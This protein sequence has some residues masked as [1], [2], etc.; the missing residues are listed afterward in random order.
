MACNKALSTVACSFQFTNIADED[1]YL[2]KCNTPLEGLDSKF[3]TVS[4]EGCPVPYEGPIFYCMPPTKD[5]FVPL[6]AGEKISASVQITD[7]FSIDTDGLYIVQYCNP[8]QYLSENEISVMSNGKVRKLSVQESIYIYLENTRHLLKP[9][10]AEKPKIDYTVHLQACDSASFSNVTKKNKETL[11]AHKKL[12]SGIDTIKGKVANNAMY[13][14]WFGAHTSS[15]ESAVKTVFTNMKNGLSGS[16][17]TYYNNGPKCKS[18]T[19][20]YTYGSFNGSTIYLCNEYYDD[21][22]Y[23]ESTGYDKE[24]TL[25]HEWTHAHSNIDDYNDTYG[26]AACKALASSNPDGAID[27]ADNYTFYYCLSK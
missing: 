5:E 3:L 18:T 25:L 4:I 26:Q 13:R 14:T 27:N 16:T 6:K 22:I 9:T 23:C 7:V 24:A 15:R 21:P 1:L 8:L 20:A 17:V 19:I 2:L 11:A 10:K 12:C